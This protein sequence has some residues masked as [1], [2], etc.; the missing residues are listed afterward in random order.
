MLSLAMKTQEALELLMRATEFR[1]RANVMR[2]RSHGL[3]SA[4]TRADLLAAAK[5][6][7]ELA[8]NAEERARGE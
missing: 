7:E 8:K 4:I 5:T 2:T 1:V 6:Y 3:I